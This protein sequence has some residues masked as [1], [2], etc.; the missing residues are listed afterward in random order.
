MKRVKIIYF[1][2]G[3]IIGAAAVFLL[4][5]SESSRSRS[6]PSQ[7]LRLHSHGGWRTDGDIWVYPDDTFLIRDYDAHSGVIVTEGN[8]RQ[9]GL[10]SSIVAM[11]DARQAWRITTS[12]LNEEVATIT[13]KGLALGVTDSNHAFLEF[14]LPGRTLV[15]DFYA[16]DSFAKLSTDAKQLR[17]FAELEAAFYQLIK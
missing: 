16:A 3:A 12:S 15:A 13:P 9:E 4:Q 1:V 11:A 10:F 6:N 8:G 2:G 17:A 7:F 14:R 5:H